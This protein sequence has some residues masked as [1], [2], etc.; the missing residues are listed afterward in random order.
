MPLCTIAIS[1]ELDMCGWAFVSFTLPCVAHLVCPIPILP[2]NVCKFD[3]LFTWSTLPTPFLT[4]IWLSANVATPTL[5]YPL[6]SI[7]F[8]PLTRIFDA[9]ISPRYPMMEHIFNLYSL[10]DVKYMSENF[11]MKYF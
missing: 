2:G 1:P 10:C 5:S 9:E 4:R 6:Y 3:L 8:N 7:R 11:P